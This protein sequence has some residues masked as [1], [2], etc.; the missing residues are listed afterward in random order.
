MDLKVA[1][2]MW[3]INA[4]FGI[5]VSKQTCYRA[6]SEARMKL[7]GTLDDHYHMLPAYIA[8]LKKVNRNGTF[9]LVLDRATPDS[10]V[11]FKRL[12]LCF[13]SIARG[14]LEGCRRVIGLDGWFLK[15]ELKGQLL[16][17][18]GK[19][20]NNQMFPIAWAVVEGENQAS[21]T[22]DLR[23][24]HIRQLSKTIA[25]EVAMELRN[26]HALKLIIHLPSSSPWL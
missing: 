4:L 2:M 17:A 9:E 1:D 21:W 19:D 7:L 18:V 10:L 16:S 3:E 12:Y 26:L 23:E 24:L 11:R 8:E 6:R 22:W 25:V 20:G 13:D 15:T 14:F 5:T